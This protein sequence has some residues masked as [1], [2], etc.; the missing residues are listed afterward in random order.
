[1][2]LVA[3]TVATEQNTRKAE[4]DAAAKEAQADSA[5]AA[6]EAAR[7]E[8]N[9]VMELTDAYM[10]AL[11]VY[12]ETGQGKEDLRK[13]AFE[14]IDAMNLEGHELEI[15]AGNYANLTERIKEYNAAKA[16]KAVS[17]S[18]TSMSCH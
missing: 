7:E 14:A 12:E 8:L 13:A 9:A 2:A 5:K 18:N 3:N 4:E 1:M 6:A 11:K 16:G 17:T 15:L 10:D